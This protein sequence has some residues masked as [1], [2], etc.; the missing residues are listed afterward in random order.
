M[1]FVQ[2]RFFAEN[3][4]WLVFYL[5]FYPFMMY[6]EFYTLPPYTLPWPYILVNSNNPS[7]GLRYLRRHSENVR[8]VIIDVGISI[9][10]DPNVREYPGGPA[11][12][13]KEQ[14][15]LYRRIVSLLPGAEV[16]VTVPDYPDDYHPGQL[17]L[18]PGKTNIERTMDNI[19]YAV[20]EYPDI[21]W[22]IPVQGHNKDPRSVEYAI[23]LLRV[24]EI[25]ERYK[26]FAIANLCVERIPQI[27]IETCA[28]ARRL[29][30]GKSLHVFGPRIPEV[31]HLV[32][33]RII[34]SFD[35]HAWTRPNGLAERC[36]LRPLHKKRASAKTLLEREIFFLAWVITLNKYLPMDNVNVN[37]YKRMFKKK[38][39]VAGVSTLDSFTVLHSPG[40]KEPV[41]AIRAVQEQRE[42]PTRHM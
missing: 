24:Y 37:F 27:I 2:S 5:S 30:P 17:W 23:T 8:S 13:I 25:T 31:V 36:Y 4:E 22:L 38:L 19:I 28:R 26:K 15:S 1:I 41:K 39:K 21:N 10:K 42:I 33:N 3:R 6:Y 20:R 29:L 35:S 14:A 16:Y 9:F 40:V 34:D 7:I 32:K 12:K 11:K 18:S